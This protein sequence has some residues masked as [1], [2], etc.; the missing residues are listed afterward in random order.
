MKNL[1]TLF[2][3]ALTTFLSAQITY[4]STHTPKINQVYRFKEV[5]SLV[6]S[7]LDVGQ[8]G[9]SRT[10]NFANLKTTNETSVQ[11][12]LDPAKTPKGSQFPTATLAEQYVDDGE[13]AYD[14]IR[15]TTSAYEIIGS[16]NSNEVEKYTNPLVGIRFPMTYNSTFKDTAV[17]VTPDLSSG[18][19]DT[20]IIFT[21]V[22][23]DAWGSIT[24]P[25]GTFNC[26]RVKTV[27]K[28]NL[29]FFGITIPITGT[30]FNFITTNYG[31]PVL[32][33]ATI[34]SPAFP[35]L[36]EVSASLLDRLSTSTKDISNTAS[37]TAYPNPATTE[38]VIEMDL[39]DVKQAA[40]SLIDVNGRTVLRKTLQEGIGSKTNIALDV[41]K[42]PPG[43]Y[44]AIIASEKGQIGMK[45]IMV[46]R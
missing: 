16:A 39:T 5:D 30:I 41:S 29:V 8:A 38:T 3:I 28:T 13:T 45:K 7:T 40:I 34:E 9:A 15:I 1:L 27:A 21:D 20:S 10:W 25:L 17:I 19:N 35:D 24:T 32:E 36:A 44:Y 2:F 37:V 46:N 33:K 18:M 23:A 42:I 11:T 14:Y 31:V 43:I 26:L 22:I 6:A 12:F 4:N